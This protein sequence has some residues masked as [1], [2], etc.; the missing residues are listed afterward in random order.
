MPSLKVRYHPDAK[1][2]LAEALEWYAARDPAVAA[3]FADV[4]AAKLAEVSKTP[5]LWARHADGTRQVLLHPFSDL[6]IVRERRRVLQLVAVAHTSRR[7][8]YWRKRLKD[9]I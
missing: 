7:S 3:R 6:L 8:S 2:E 9:D 4:Y 1:V 5:R